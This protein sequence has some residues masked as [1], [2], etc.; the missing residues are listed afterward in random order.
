MIFLYIYN[1]DWGRGFS[2]T[3]SLFNLSH[4]RQTARNTESSPL[5]SVPSDEHTAERVDG[6]GTQR[7]LF[8]TVHEMPYA[9]S[10]TA[11]HTLIVTALPP[12]VKPA[13][14]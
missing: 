6:P 13:A 11:Q 1:A 3:G 8:V 14:R 10:S 2:S 12:N 9:H 4:V 5:A 7:P